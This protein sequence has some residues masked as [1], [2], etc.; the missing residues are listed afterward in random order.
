LEAQPLLYSGIFGAWDDDSGAGYDA[1]FAYEVP[2]RGDYQLL[3]TR[4]PTGDSFGA[5]R[6]LVG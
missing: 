3:I 1:A 6:L 2:E 5:Y 4:S